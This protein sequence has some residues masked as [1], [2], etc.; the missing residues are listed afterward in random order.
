MEK[1]KEVNEKIQEEKKQKELRADTKNY[2][3]T[4]CQ[5]SKDIPRRIIKAPSC[6]RTPMNICTGYVVCN[7]KAPNSGKF[8]RMTVCSSELCGEKDA[9]AC[10]E[11]KG[12]SSVKPD[13]VESNTVSRAVRN[14]IQSGVSVQ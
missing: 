12:Y 8:I 2:D 6:G 9:V 5:W 4:S 13:D 3:A 10:K 11:D 7:E 1:A 14:I